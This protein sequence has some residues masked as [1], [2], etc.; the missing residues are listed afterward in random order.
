MR[1]STSS[2]TF[3]HLGLL[4][5]NRIHS[6]L[7]T[8]PPNYASS[9]SRTLLRIHLV[10]FWGSLELSI[11]HLFLPGSITSKKSLLSSTSHL[12][13]S[14]LPLSNPSPLP[15]HPIPPPRSVPRACT[16]LIPFRKEDHQKPDLRLHPPDLLQTCNL[17]IFALFKQPHPRVC[18]QLES[19]SIPF[20]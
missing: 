15:L 6:I 3:R 9:A 10:H 4:F 11:R 17:Q 14:P 13:P 19:N 18:C 12:S 8:D 1:P 16:F 5:H 20:V 7:N 2:D